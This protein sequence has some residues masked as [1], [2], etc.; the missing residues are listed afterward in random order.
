[1]TSNPYEDLDLF[2]R[3]YDQKVWSHA[4]GMVWFPP[5]LAGHADE[6]RG[7]VPVVLGHRQGH[8][9]PDRVPPDAQPVLRD[10][11]RRPPPQRGGGEREDPREDLLAGRRRRRLLQ[12]ERVHGG[13]EGRGAGRDQPAWR[14]DGVVQPGAIGTGQLQPRR[15]LRRA[16]TSTS[17]RVSASSSDT[18]PRRSRSSS[19]RPASSAQFDA[20]PPSEPKQPQYE[21]VGCPS[22][23]ATDIIPAG[24]AS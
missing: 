1:M 12:Q 8:A 18:C 16:S 7:G 3:T 20:P 13:G 5:Y 9:V 10:P 2:A 17:T 14:C 4:F 15:R 24:Q 6:S 19:T 22:T 23:G 11:V 21:C